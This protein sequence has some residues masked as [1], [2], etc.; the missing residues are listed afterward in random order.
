MVREK[1]STILGFRTINTI[2]IA[3][4]REVIVYAIKMDP[5]HLFKGAN[6]VHEVI[7]SREKGNG[8]DER[9]KT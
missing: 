7:I 2:D 3:T 5:F 1:S 8:R 4:I 6:A 9:R